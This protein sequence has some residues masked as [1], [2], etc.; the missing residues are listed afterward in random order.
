MVR[1]DVLGAIKRSA[2]K[3]M[4]LGGLNQDLCFA[5]DLMQVQ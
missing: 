1:D 5:G 3:L 2:I 4:N